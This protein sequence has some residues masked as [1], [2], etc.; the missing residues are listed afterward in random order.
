M[1]QSI[2][3]DPEK[4]ARSLENELRA[5]ADTNTT[6][7]LLAAAESLANLRGIDIGVEVASIR[8]KLKRAGCLP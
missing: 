8:Q 3:R 2:L 4:A 6:A 7:A 1:V 5:G